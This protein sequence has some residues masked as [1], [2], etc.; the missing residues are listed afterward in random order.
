MLVTNTDW[1]DP[2]TR[3]LAKSYQAWK[4]VA[5][6]C[7]TLNF[8]VI[9]DNDAPDELDGCLIVGPKALQD[10]VEELEAGTFAVYVL[11]QIGKGGARLCPVTG[12]WR[13]GDAADDALFWYA[14]DLG[15][16]RPC[17]PSQLPPRAKLEL[18]VRLV[19]EMQVGASCT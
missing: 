8:W 19:P 16:L 4:C 18:A 17:T 13:E 3:D 11:D 7:E 14:N 6:T 1:A 5:W 12:L 9:V 15:E 10:A 2:A